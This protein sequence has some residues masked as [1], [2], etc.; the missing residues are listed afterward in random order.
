MLSEVEMKKQDL[1]VNAM[2]SEFKRTNGGWETFEI[3]DAMEF[4][5][6]SVAEM[7]MN[8]VNV[9]LSVFDCTGEVRAETYFGVGNITA[10]A[11]FPGGM[12]QVRVRPKG[13]D[14]F[15]PWIGKAVCC[16]KLMGRPVPE[17]ILRHGKEE[18]K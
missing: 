8:G 11:A 5:A 12:E 2:K 18:K 14:G 9:V 16:A 10:A 4:V 6:D 7:A 1:L 15:N 17:F 3:Q 13:G